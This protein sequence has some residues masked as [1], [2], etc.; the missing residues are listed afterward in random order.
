MPTRPV[1]VLLG[2][3]LP[4]LG[5][6]SA[7]AAAD[8]PGNTTTRATLRVTTTYMPGEFE[9][10]TDSDWYRVQL[11]AGVD[12]AVS[13]ETRSG[14]GIRLNVR[15]AGG[16]VLRRVGGDGYTDVGT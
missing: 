2:A 11:A 16:R 4:L 9:S 7:A 6:G 1:A 3:A 14:Y 13:G 10:V 12:Y 5:S 8:V 15:D